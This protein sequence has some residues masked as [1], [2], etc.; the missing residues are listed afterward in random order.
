MI[1]R[2]FVLVL[3]GALSVSAAHAALVYQI[4]VDTASISGTTGFVD[5]QFNPGTAAAPSATATVTAFS[6]SGALA[7]FGGFTDLTGDVVLLAPAMLPSFGNSTVFN[8]ALGQATFGSV[9]HLQ[10]G[11]D[12]PWLNASGNVATGFSLFL[13]GQNFEALL[14]GDPGGAVVQIDL[15]PGGTVN[16][17]NLAGAPVSVSQVPL[18][19]SWVLITGGLVLLAGIGRSTTTCASS[20]STRPF[21]Q[22]SVGASPSFNT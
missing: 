18:P 10:L 5:L 6:L 2:L 8:D 4:D 11:F 19:A 12:G 1:K 21:S 3:L 20:R 17:S 13:L 22:S 16:V 9:L 15:A 7:Q 14:P